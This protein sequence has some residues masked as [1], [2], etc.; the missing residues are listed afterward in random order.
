MGD[1]VVED[2]DKLH[3]FDLYCRKEACEVSWSE[4]MKKLSIQSAMCM[5]NLDRSLKRVKCLNKD[6]RDTY[7]T[8]MADD[9]TQACVAKDNEKTLVV[10]NMIF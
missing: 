5:F 2:G 10:A 1:D 8:S 6:E 3:L 4:N 9:A 7:F